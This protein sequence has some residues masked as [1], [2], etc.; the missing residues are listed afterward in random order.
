MHYVSSTWV[1]TESSTFLPYHINVALSIELTP[2]QPNL[3]YQDTH[4][5]RLLILQI[6]ISPGVWE[7]IQ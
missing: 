4:T 2:P 5:R 6:H 7:V 3:K 1:P